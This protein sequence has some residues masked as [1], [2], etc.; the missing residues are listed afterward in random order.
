[1]LCPNCGQANDEHAHSCSACGIY[2]IKWMIQQHKRE[3]EQQRAPAKTRARAPRW[4][5][6]H[7]FSRAA[8]GLAIALAFLAGLLAA[9]LLKPRAPDPW[10]V[11]G[12][13]PVP[14]GIMLARTER[15]FGEAK[16]AAEALG[17]ALDPKELGGFFQQG[18][19][20]FRL[21]NLRQ[22][23]A[24]AG[25]G[26]AREP[27]APGDRDAPPERPVACRLGGRWERFAAPP[28]REALECWALDRE[29]KRRYETDWAYWE[30]T[31]VR[32][33]WV[34]EKRGWAYFTRAEDRALF[35]EHIRRR[36]GTEARAADERESRGVLRDA[37]GNPAVLK[38]A[39]LTAYRTRLRR[40]GALYR[41]EKLGS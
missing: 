9:W 31:R 29:L 11:Y 16:P 17:I 18:V 41:L 6:P 28:G 5:L 30:I 32:L 35:A 13:L 26:P 7:Q 25:V 34:P 22:A 2:F 23:A 14:E 36:L 20:S 4:T 8:L 40:E 21:G 33:R 3:R 12:P 37:R 39:L 10:L 1:M 27:P 19:D 15:L 38:A 24:D